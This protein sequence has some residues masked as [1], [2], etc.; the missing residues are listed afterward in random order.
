MRVG[1]SIGWMDK[2][3]LEATDMPSLFGYAGYADPDDAEPVPLRKAG[4]AGR[5]ACQIDGGR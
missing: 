3:E 1:Q 4:H 5:P 2:Q